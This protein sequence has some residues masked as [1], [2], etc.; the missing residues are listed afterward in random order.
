MK[1]SLLIS[2]ALFGICLHC[3]TMTYA[4]ERYVRKPLPAPDFFV[5]KQDVEYREKLPPF[6]LPKQED[7]TSPQSIEKVNEPTFYPVEE[8]QA[9]IPQEPEFDPTLDVDLSSSTSNENNQSNNTP[10]YQKEYDAYLQDLNAI[11]QSGKAP[12]RLDLEKDL[13]A[14]DSE[15]KIELDLDG[16]L[17]TQSLNQNSNNALVLA[18]LAPKPSAG[19]EATSAEI[20]DSV[21]IIRMPKNLQTTSTQKAEKPTH[22]RMVVSKNPE[23]AENPF[24]DDIAE[25]V[26][27]NALLSALEDKTQETSPQT[28][29]DTVEKDEPQQNDILPVETETAPDAATDFSL[30]NPFL[31]SEASP[32]DSAAQNFPAYSAPSEENSPEELSEEKEANNFAAELDKLHQTSMDNMKNAAQENKR[33]HTSSSS[34]SGGVSGFNLGPNMV[35]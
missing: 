1:K 10:T 19:D 15:D 6:N 21:E 25:G 33:K 29:A 20:I 28:V 2:V 16:N 9:P 14:M 18:Q 35:R 8:K 4:Q 31:S 3:S 26:D 17:K 11:A 30:T 23:T 24:A 27:A 34:G 5:P 12:Y 32:T 7:T 22:K 13:S